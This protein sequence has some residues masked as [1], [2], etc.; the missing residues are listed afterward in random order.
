VAVRF[1]DLRTHETV[2]YDTFRKAAEA[3][4]LLA[5]DHEFESALQ[6]PTHY[7]MPHRIRALFCT[8]LAFGSPSIPLALYNRFEESLSSG[9]TPP[10]MSS[11]LCRY[12]LEIILRNMGTSLCN[13]NIPLTNMN[14]HMITDV[15]SNSLDLNEFLE[16]NE[17]QSEEQLMVLLYQAEKDIVNQIFLAVDTNGSLMVFKD[18]PG[19]TGKTYVCNTLYK[20]FALRGINEQIVC[21][22][23]TGIAAT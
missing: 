10:D 3:R 15:P 17:E 11:D 13:F 5:S 7:Q 14:S 22:A 2:L 8:I 16:I 23:S 12:H 19:G 4:G 9:I 1:Q 6:E 20:I 18:G 21:V